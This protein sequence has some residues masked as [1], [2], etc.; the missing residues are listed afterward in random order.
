MR[1]TKLTISAFGPYAGETEIPLSDLGTSGLYLITG[2]TGAGKTTIFDAITYALYGEP[3]GDNRNAKMLRSEYASPDTPT[4]VEME[5]TYGGKDYTIRRSPE[6]VRPKKR[7]EGFTTSPESAELYLPDETV[8]SGMKNVG[9]EIINIMGITRRQF[10]Q[11]AMIAQGDFLKLLLA[12]TDERK[13]IFQKLF[14]T[15]KYAVLQNKISEIYN[16]SC[17]HIDMEKAGLREFSKT[18]SHDK[19][20]EYA[21]RIALAASGD[22]RTEDT[23]VLID[24][25]IKRDSARLEVLK[26]ESEEI[27]KELA[28]VN[29]QIERAQNRQRLENQLKLASADLKGKSEQAE[30]YAD[31]LKREKQ[32]QPKAEKLTGDLAVIDSEAD[33]YDEADKTENQLKGIQKELKT[34]Q[35]QLAETNKLYSAAVSDLDAL[36]AEDTALADAGENRE[37]LLHETDA[38]KELRSQLIALSAQIADLAASSAK[39]EKAQ[40]QFLKAD[41]KRVTTQEK[42]SAAYSAFLAEQ[43]GII[44]AALEDNVPCPVCGSLH[45]PAP[46]KPSQEAPTEAELEKLRKAADSARDKAAEDSRIAAELKAAHEEK[47]R[48]IAVSVK[49]L[50]EC[51]PDHAQKVCAEK[52]AETERR[53]ADL[54]NELSAAEKRIARKAELTGLIPAKE[55]EKTALSEKSAQ[56]TAEIS[57]AQASEKAISAQLEQMRSK[58]KFASKA[59]AQKAADTLRSEITAIREGLKNAQQLFDSA[60]AQASQAE[61]KVRQLTAQLTAEE[62]VDG[63]AE[64]EKAEKLSSRK[65]TATDDINRIFAYISGNTELL[66]RFNDCAGRLS[67]LEEKYQWL[68]PIY[69]TVIG[70]TKGKERISLETYIQTAYFD[71]I[72]ARA[73]NRLSIMTSGQYTLVRSETALDGRL[74]AGLDLDVIDHNNGT[75]RSVKTLSGGESF[76]ASLC[77]ALGLSDEIQ[78]SA[79]GIQLDTM[80]VDEGFGSLDDN[81]LRQAVRAL[82]DLSDGNRLVGI[83][84]H[85]SELKDK[86]DKRLIVTKKGGVSKVDIV[87]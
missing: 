31:L 20:D 68:K 34:V 62:P 2:D 48:Q 28:E 57:A 4:F 66:K 59:Q 79:G 1:P 75:V 87:L 58:L 52:T 65:N 35:S 74:K 18:I 72:I 61:G 21:D 46:A 11:I 37:R 55:T 81:A 12:G 23:A 78:S 60:S 14:R 45:H 51:E 84:S 3:S 22:M 24:T 25:I 85:V 69:D 6:Y 16:D 70:L 49:S 30:Q 5:F 50:L 32:N 73:N 83:I 82:A 43:A 33:K 44:A 67:A 9:E 26:R 47:S 7:G 17:G 15:E 76:Q 10:T 29:R 77:L 36:K 38:C 19:E 27:D 56:L 53:L 13:K 54:T 63:T 39:L 8:V 80:F 40:E 71:K 86:I 42:Y 41:T 64:K